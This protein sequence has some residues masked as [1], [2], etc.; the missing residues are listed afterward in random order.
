MPTPHLHHCEAREWLRRGY[1]TPAK[2]RELHARI[3]ARRGLAA[4]DRLVE[5]M[6]REY[7][8]ATMTA[9]DGEV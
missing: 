9:S 5:D 4:A 3:R 2:V 8:H 1:T 7:R 6:R